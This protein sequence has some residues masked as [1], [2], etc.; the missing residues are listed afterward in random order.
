MKKILIVDDEEKIRYLIE[1]YLKEAGFS[2]YLA[3]NGEEALALANQHQFALVIMDIMMPGMDGYRCYKYLKKIQD[4]PCI[5]LSALSNEDDKLYAFSLGA[6]D[7]V[8]K[9]F[10][11]KELVVRINLILSKQ[12]N[13]PVNN[14]NYRFK[15]LTLNFNEH[16]LLIDNQERK[17]SLKA[18]SLLAYLIRNKG[19][20]CERN[21]LLSA[22]WRDSE[23]DERT[24]DTHIKL[25]RKALIPYEYLIITIRGIGYQFKEISND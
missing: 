12:N 17:L 19:K 24:L 8:V 5:F 1:R 13:V 21:E 2:P 20:V 22:I 16:V 18:F 15:H 11:V 25:I 7:Y 9:P 14:D 6:S 4:I 10:S 23:S 3:L